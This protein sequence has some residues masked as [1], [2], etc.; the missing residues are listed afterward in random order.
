MPLDDIDWLLVFETKAELYYRRFC[1]IA[2]GKSDP[3]RDSNESENVN[4]WNAWQTSGDFA[5]DAMEA[6]GKAWARIEGR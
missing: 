4:Q 6:L 1:R 2:P 3:L 5:V